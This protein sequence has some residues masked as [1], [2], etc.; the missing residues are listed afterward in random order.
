MDLKT[1]GEQLQMLRKQAGMSQEQLAKA[2]ERLACA[3]PAEEYRV[4]DGTL[5][6]RWEQARVQRGR[7]WKPTRPYLLHLIRLFAGQLDIEIA[8]QWALQAGYQFGTTELQ[9][10]F[11]HAIT[12]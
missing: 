9:E 11:P 12:V 1:F 4:I 8:R 5:I 6:S 7:Q 10:V 2:L 3:G